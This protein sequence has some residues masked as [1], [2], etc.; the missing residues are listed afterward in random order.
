MPYYLL[1]RSSHFVRI[2]VLLCCVVFVLSLALPNH[3]RAHDGQPHTPEATA[4]VVVSASPGGENRVYLP[5][6]IA[7]GEFISQPSE[8]ATDPHAVNDYTLAEEARK[9][10][11]PA[12]APEAKDILAPQAP[13]DLITTGQWGPVIG[14]PFVFATATN[15]PDGRILTWGGNNPTSFSGG[16]STYATVW[17][18]SNGQFLSRNHNDHSMFCSIPT[19]MEDGRVFT[20][21]GD[22]TRARTSIFDYRTNTWTRVQ[23]MA[24]GRWYNG[25]VNL[26]NGKIVTTLGDPGNNYPEIW[27]EGQGWSLLTGANL[28]NGMLNQ[29]GYQFTWLPY[30][31]LA[32]DG[33]I[34]HTGPAAQM[35]WITPTGSGGISPAGTGATWYPKYSAGVMYEPGKILIAGGMT[36][37][38]VKTSVNKAMIIDVNGAT[39]Q[40]TVVASMAFSRTFVSPVVLP[41]GEVMVIGGNTTGAE[42]SDTGSV[43]PTEIWNPATQT[44]RT[45]ASISVPRNYHSVAL[46]MPDGRVFSGGGGLCACS[47]DHPDAQLFS[48]PYLFDATGAPA[49]RPTISAAP[50]AVTYGRVF[51]VT[52]TNGVQ[53]FTLIKMSATTHNLNS[54]L[55]FMSVP[56]TN[57]SA[58]NYQLTLNSNANVLTPGYWM[59]F[60]ID[61]QGVPSVAKVMQVVSSGAPRVTS[62]GD[63]NTVVGT[64]VN[65]AIAATDPNGDVLTFSATGLPTGL[66]INPGTGVIAGTPTTP[67]IY[68]VALTVS[69]GATPVVVN[70]SWTISGSSGSSQYRYVRLVALSEINGNPWASANELN[71][72]D[73][74]GATLSRTGWVATANSQETVGEDGRASNVLDNYTGI[75][76]TQWYTTNP[77]HPHWLRLDMGAPKSIGGFRYLPRTGT[78]DG[79][80]KDYA[81]YVS[82]DGVNWGSPV[83]QGTFA[84]NQSEKTVTFNLNPNTPPTLT[85]IANQTHTVNSAVSVPTSASDANGD[86]LTFSALGLPTGIV[87]NPSTGVMAG[88]PTV[89]ATHSVTVTV[90]D[91]RGGSASSSFVWLIQAP[92]QTLVINPINSLPKPVNTPISYTASSSNGVNPRYKWLWGD[93]SP[94]TAYDPSPTATHSF[95]QPGLYVVQVTVTDDSALE[96]SFTFV[97]AVHAPNTANRPTTSSNIAFELRSGANNRVWVVN[98]DNDSVSVFDAVTNAKLAEINVGL[99]PR[100]VAIAPNGNAWVVN[101]GSANISVI[102]PNT[103][104]IAQ[105]VTLP[106]A[107]QP[108]GL[109]FAPAGGSAFVALEAT[110]RLLKIDA[111]TGAQ[112]GALDVGPNVRGVAVSADGASVLV[113]RFVTPRM[114]G[115]ETAAVTTNP[116]A[117]GEV[118]VVDAGAGALTIARTVVLQHSDKPDTENQGGGLPNYVGAVAISPDGLSAWAPSKQDNIK[119]GV[120]RNGNQLNFQNSVRAVVSRIDLSGSTTDDLAGRVD[121]D[122]SSMGSASAFDPFGSYLFTAL[123]TSREV[124][125]IDAYAK[126]E[127]WRFSVGRAPQGLVVSPDGLRLYVNNF[128]DRTVQVFDLSALMNRGEKTFPLLATL[129]PITTEKLTAQ[130]LNGKRLF[131]DAADPRLA[132]DGYMSCASCHN[133]GGQDGRV[134]DFTGVG[135]GLR[136]TVALRGRGGGQGF[137][138]WSA[139]FDE[140]QDFE[141]QIRNFA[142]GL[143]LMTDAQFN[144]GTR[145]TPLGDPK[146]GVS[147]DLDALA[148]Y[149]ASL[150]TFALSPF[151]NSDETLT[152]DATAGRAIFLSANC[153]QCHG[154]VAF[155][156]SGNATL[157]NIGTLKPSSGQRLGGALNGIDPPT[158]R[159]TWASAPYLHDG[160]AATLNAAVSA[161]SAVTSV[162]ALDATQIQQVVAY[163]QQIGSLETTAPAPNVG[164]SVSLSAPANNAVF[165]VPATVNITATASDSDGT[166]SK[167]EF[168]NGATKLGEDATAPYT[169]S[170]TIVTTGTYTLTAVA[171]D[172]EGTATTSAVVTITV[173]PPPPNVPPSVSLSAP[174]NNQ[175]FTTPATVTLAANASDSDGTV[176]KVEFFSGTTKLGED[177]ATPYTYNWTNVTTG[178][179]TLTAVATDNSGAT[180]NSASVTITVSAAV[181]CALPT[182]W[183][184]VNIGSPALAGSVCQNNG[185]WTVAGGG[186]DIWGTSDQFRFAYQSANVGTNATIIARVN[187][188][189][190]T[191]YWAKSGVMFRNGTGATARF[192]M[193][194]HYPNNEVSFYWRTATGGSA[195]WNGARVGGTASIKWVRLTKTGNSYTAYYSTAIGVPTS[196]QWVQIGTAVSATLTNPKAGLAVT[197]RNNALLNTSTFTGVSVSSP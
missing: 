91:G 14:W 129:N 95:A 44:W 188:V 10:D 41:T 17:D 67:G 74:T 163:L 49:P 106:Y 189:Q 52:A 152:A 66:S 176:S 130:V 182:G 64:S 155:S 104:A 57:L 93:G 160:S 142:G 27:T 143:G 12:F 72:L 79:T 121:H 29:S 153:A 168:F 178:T 164:P 73:A 9:R 167:V 39:P 92:P 109:A 82:N 177:V 134:W 69:D 85:V 131:Y 23:D 4:D 191:E 181:S 185:T 16:T 78:P 196:G 70:F 108:F 126:Q 114:L 43:L 21:G 55:R 162:V 80:I 15:L 115:E 46:L 122:N 42:F 100:S 140:V 149:L 35:N 165:I 135:E 30:L 53:K 136:N 7:Q 174:A 193:V 116:T 76:H 68:P 50:D 63:L 169:S 1:P 89:A 25:N 146:A 22:G 132:R 190:A 119:R 51:S 139:N 88:T 90:S 83:A 24:V 183:V 19:M 194:A 175:A 147:A 75:W 40:K 6:I 111:G 148:A 86:P 37:G 28:Q 159:D 158:L 138:H 81:F 161:H 58:G 31:Y 96:R 20:N 124:A 151:R 38:S 56:F 105:T 118:I 154:G 36:S 45:V 120:L 172:N 71:V 33:R 34:I 133:D 197:A 127:I 123:E 61:A 117:G 186:A 179:Y 128:M 94:E 65:L 150:N 156:S 125:V 47:A 102:N 157:F 107:S 112:T 187:S 26:P 170:W 59:L 3:A 137:L 60:A 5:V 184:S 8:S 195:N 87:I 2:S 54:D 77:A 103:L 48:P 144:T 113:S 13:E 98:Q 99:M 171:T 62:P 97:Q 145:N 11:E 110:G 166:V 180:T 141:A 84:S 173:N 192:V 18:P 32:P 101:K